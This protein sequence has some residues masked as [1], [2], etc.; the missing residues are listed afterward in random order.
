MDNNVMPNLEKKINNTK[1]REVACKF[2][3]YTLGFDTVGAAD[4]GLRHVSNSQMG[5]D[6]LAIHPFKELKG[7]R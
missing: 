5:R 4:L 1:L 7:G 3:L 6:T 2:A